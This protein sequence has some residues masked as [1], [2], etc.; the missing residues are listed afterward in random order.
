MGPFSKKTQKLLLKRFTSLATSCHHNSAMIT[1]RQKFTAKITL[2]GIFSFHFYHWN[3]FK[4]IRLA[5]TLWTRNLP[6]FSATSGAVW[7]HGSRRQ[8]ITIDCSITWH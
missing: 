2:C 6:K 8:P 1:D 5:Y 3:Q 7:Q 4:V